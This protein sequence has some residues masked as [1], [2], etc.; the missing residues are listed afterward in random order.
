MKIINGTI[1]TGSKLV[2]RALDVVFSTG[3]GYIGQV[4]IQN[5]TN[6]FHYKLGLM[7]IVIV[8]VPEGY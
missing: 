8:D 6:N 2:K 1:F 5:R 4:R 3:I 7:S